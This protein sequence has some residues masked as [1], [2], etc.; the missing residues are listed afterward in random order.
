MSKRRKF[1]EIQFNW[2]VTMTLQQVH[3]TQFVYRKLLD[4]MSRPGEILQLDHEN[5][6]ET[7]AFD[8]F[9]ATTG[10]LFTLLD[11]EVSY[12]IISESSEKISQVITTYTLAQPAPIEEADFII[13]LEDA[14]K[15]DVSSALQQCKIGTLRDPHESATWIIE[16]TLHAGNEVTLTGPGIQTESSLV[17]GLSEEFWDIR[18]ERLREFPLG[19]D[20]I[21]TND[22]NEI[23]CMP[24]TTKVERV[25]V[26]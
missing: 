23:T 9:Q 6:I 4:C 15:S 10:L 12:Y 5:R 13:V 21:F 1:N 20:V 17:L 14:K 19:F 24:R 8:C 16:S 18:K 2:E 7:T 26:N 25:V 11:Q 22:Q 3:Y